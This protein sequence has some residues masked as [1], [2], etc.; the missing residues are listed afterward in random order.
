MFQKFLQIAFRGKQR[1]PWVY[2]LTA[3]TIPRSLRRRLYDKYLETKV[4]F[5]ADARTVFETIHGRNWWGSQESRSGVGSELA[6]TEGLRR[7]LEH[8]LNRH[9]DEVATFLDAPCGD[10]NWLHAVTFPEGMRY[11]GGDIV[12]V[13][14]T[15][16]A[17]KFQS[18]RRSF[19]DLDIIAGPIPAAD[20]WLCRDVLIHFPFAEGCAVVD[21]FRASKCKYFLSTTYPKEKNLTDIHLGWFR[22]VNLAISPFKLGEPIELIHDAPQDQPG[23]YLGIWRNPNL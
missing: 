7:T 3:M 6:R 9:R 2:K 19:M 18:D 23:R 15:A 1:M 5:G 22:P 21:H 8:W 17:D 10:F 4:N 12:Q 16:N 14:V 11:I 13:L 20:A